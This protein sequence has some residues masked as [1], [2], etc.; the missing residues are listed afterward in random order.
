MLSR[1]QFITT[2]AATLAA[3]AVA[4]QQVQWI[5]SQTVLPPMNPYYMPQQVEVG[6]DFRVGNIYVY[7]HQFLLYH[8]IAPG[9]AIRYGVALGEQGREF[10]GVAT[11]SRKRAWPTWTPTPNMLRVDPAR[12]RPLAA[13]VPGG[14]VDNPMGSAA[15]YLAV[16]GRE[17]LYRIHGTNLPETIG[18]QYDFGCIKL[19]NDHMTQLY[20]MT[21]VG[22]T[23]YVA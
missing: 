14:H 5:R 8:V 20:E 2:A 22:A 1:R 11:V 16:N 17:T 12:Y 21:R 23:V 4:Q 3:P 19:R 13:G 6:S 9:K 18:L 7:N 10:R 15:L